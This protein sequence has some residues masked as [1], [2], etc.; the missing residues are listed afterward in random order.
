LSRNNRNTIC[1][2]VASGVVSFI[3]NKFIN[4]RKDENEEL[5]INMIGGEPL[6]EFGII[7][8]IV[9][10]MQENFKINHIN[11]KLRF[12]ISSN[13]IN[14]NEEKIN[15]LK[16]NNFSVYASIDG[17]KKYHELNRVDVFGNCH[18]EKIFI[19]LMK[20]REKQ[21]PIVVNMVITPN[22]VSGLIKNFLYLYRELNID[23]ISINFAYEQDWDSES[24]ASL[25]QQVN[26]LCQIYYNI[27]VY[28]KGGFFLN[29]IDDQII[30]TL[31]ANRKLDINY[32]GAGKVVFS[33]DDNGKILPCG[34]LSY[35]G[36]DH[37]DFAIG[38]FLTGISNEKVTKVR[39][40]FNSI[41]DNTCSTC[42]FSDR[43]KYFCPA[44]N[45]LCKS[46]DDSRVSNICS[47]N[48]IIIIETDK[49][50][51]RLLIHE[52]KLLASKLKIVF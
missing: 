2:D 8:F 48:K 42:D 22:N 26:V 28:K 11:N 35:I 25:V 19:N 45:L 5:M 32:C 30:R 46:I 13:I 1:P 39:N 14:L 36:Y 50:I 7:Q 47:I 29:V 17:I 43:C 49:L 20:L 44:I 12:E 51:N 16:N 23:D 4:E 9:S 37:N 31:K 40:I 6:L 3:F 21:V 18:Y 10:K 27:I 15:Y 38:D 41:L 52:S 33:F 24:L 34:L